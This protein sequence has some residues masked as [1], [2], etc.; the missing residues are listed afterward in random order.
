MAAADDNRILNVL[1]YEEMVKLFISILNTTEEDVKV[2]NKAAKRGQKIVLNCLNGSTWKTLKP[3]L[4]RLVIDLKIFD[5]MNEE[6]DR[7]FSVGYQVIFDKKTGK[8]GV[9]HF[10]IDTTYDKVIPTIPYIDALKG[11]PVGTM[12]FECD[13]DSDRFVLK[14]IVP[15][16]RQVTELLDYDLSPILKM[17]NIEPVS[18]VTLPDGIT[19]ED[20]GLKEL[21]IGGSFWDRDGGT[22]AGYMNGDPLADSSADETQGGTRTFE[23]PWPFPDRQLKR[24]IS[25]PEWLKSFIMVWTIMD[26]NNSSSGQVSLSKALKNSREVF[27]AYGLSWDRDEAVL[28]LN[29]LRRRGLV[30]NPRNGNR[31]DFSSEED[32][33]IVDIDPR[34]NAVW[35]RNVEYIKV[36]LTEGFLHGKE[37]FLKAIGE[38]A[39]VTEIWSK[40]PVEVNHSILRAMM[41]FDESS[42][43]VMADWIFSRPRGSAL[44]DSIALNLDYERALKDWLKLQA[45]ELAG[46]SI[47]HLTAEISPMAGGLGRVE[48]Y[49][50]NAMFE[51]GADSIYVAPWYLNIRDNAGKLQKID[52]AALPN[53]ITDITPY[54]TMETFVQGCKVRFE[55]A[56]GIL[57]IKSGDKV[58]LIPIY[59]IRDI[60]ENYPYRIINLLYEYGTCDCRA[61]I[62]EFTEFFNK[63]ALELIR[64]REVE[65]KHLKESLHEEYKAPVVDANDAQTLPV[66]AFRKAFYS[67]KDRIAPAPDRDEAFFIMNAALFSGTTHTYYN[68]AWADDFEFGKNFLRKA[69]IPDEWLW[70]FLHIFID[71][72]GSWKVV[73]DL[74]SGGVRASDVAKAVAAVHAFEVNRYDPAVELKGLTNGD[75]Y[76]Y[77]SEYFRDALRRTGASGHSQPSSEEI[78]A[79]K[80]YAKQQI[81]LDPRQ[82]VVGYFGR[83]VPEKAGRKSAF[84]DT[85]ITA[86]VKAGIQLIIYGSA[87]WT[88]TMSSELE[89]LE[90][91]LAE[92]KKEEPETYPGRFIFESMFTIDDQRK[93]LAAAD[94]QI[95]ASDRETEAAGATESDIGANAGLQLSTP[96]WEGMIPFMGDPVNRVKMTGNVLIPEKD[97]AEAYLKTVLWAEEQYRKG[98]LVK[99][100]TYAY[101]I[102]GFVDARYTAAAYL[103]F[104]NNGFAGKRAVVNPRVVG[105]IGIDGRY[106]ELTSKTTSGDIAIFKDENKFYIIG[107]KKE[108]GN[109]SK[110]LVLTLSISLDPAFAPFGG[111]RIPE[112]NIFVELVNDYGIRLKMSPVRKIYDNVV[113]YE[114]VIPE[115][116]PLPFQGMIRATSGLWQQTKYFEIIPEEYIPLEGDE[117]I[118][119]VYPLDFS[120]GAAR[121]ILFGKFGML[122]FGFDTSEGMQYANSSGI[123]GFINKAHVLVKEGVSIRTPFYHFIRYISGLCAGCVNED[124]LL[125]HM[126]SIGA[127]QAG[128]AEKIGEL[129][130]FL[131]QFTRHAEYRLIE[132]WIGGL[133]IEQLVTLM[134]GNKCV[135]S[136][137]FNTTSGAVYAETS[138]LKS[139]EAVLRGLSAGRRSDCGIINDFMDFMKYMDAL[140]KEV[141]GREEI[142]AYLQSISNE[143]ISVSLKI[144][145]LLRFVEKLNEKMEKSLVNSFIGNANLD[146][147]ETVLSYGKFDMRPFE[148]Y[149]L[150]GKWMADSAGLQDFLF[151]LK[152]V[153]G[154]GGVSFS[155]YMNYLRKLFEGVPNAGFV[156]DYLEYVGAMEV[157]EYKRFIR[158]L[159]Q[160]EVHLI[161][162]I[163]YYRVFACAPNQYGF[164]CEVDE[165]ASGLPDGGCVKLTGISRNYMRL[166]LRPGT[167]LVDLTVAGGRLSGRQDAGTG[168]ILI[169]AGLELVGALFLLRLSGS[170][171]QVNFPGL[172]RTAG[173]GKFAGDGYTLIRVRQNIL[174][175]A[176]ARQGGVTFPSEEWTGWSR[177]RSVCKLF[178]KALAGHRSGEP[179]KGHSSILQDIFVSDMGGN[180]AGPAHTCSTIS[181][182]QYPRGPA[183]VKTFSFI[184]Y[185]DGGNAANEEKYKIVFGRDYRLIFVISLMSAL[186]LPTFIGILASSG[187]SVTAIVFIL[188]IMIFPVL[189]EVLFRKVLFDDLLLRRWGIGFRAA[190]AISSLIFAVFGGMVI[191]C[192]FIPLFLLGVINVNLFVRSGNLNRSMAVYA[193]AMVLA[194][195]SQGSWYLTSGLFLMAYLTLPGGK[196]TALFDKERQASEYPAYFSG[197]LIFTLYISEVLLS[198]FDSELAYILVHTIVI[199]C[200]TAPIWEEVVWRKMILGDL[201]VKKYG[202]NVSR[203]VIISAVFFAIIHPLTNGMTFLPLNQLLLGVAA[204]YAYIKTG[205][206]R[207]AIIVHAGYNAL[208]NIFGYVFVRMFSSVDM[209]HL[210][211]NL[212]GFPFSFSLDIID[213]SLSL[214][215]LVVLFAAVKFLRPRPED[216]KR[217]YS[218]LMKGEL[219]D[220]GLAGS[221]LTDKSGPG[222]ILSD[223]PT[224]AG[225]DKTTGAGFIFLEEDGGEQNDGAA[226]SVSQDDFVKIVRE[227]M[228]I[229]MSLLFDGDTPI[230]QNM[231]SDLLYGYVSAVWRARGY[232]AQLLKKKGFFL[233]TAGENNKLTFELFLGKAREEL[234]ALEALKNEIKIYGGGNMQIRA[235]GASLTELVNELRRSGILLR[236]N[237]FIALNSGN[238]NHGLNHVLLSHEQE[239]KEWGI[240]SIEEI[241]AVIIE[242]IE[243]GRFTDNETLSAVIKFPRGNGSV[244]VVLSILGDEV[245]TAYPVDKAPSI[246]VDKNTS[247]PKQDTRLLE[248]VSILQPL[249]SLERAEIAALIAGGTIDIKHWEETAHKCSDILQNG[250]LIPVVKKSLPSKSVAVLA[251]ALA[252]L[253]HPQITSAEETS[254]LLRSILDRFA[255]GYAAAN[256]N[257]SEAKETGRKLSRSI[258]YLLYIAG[259]YRLNVPR[260]QLADALIETARTIGCGVNE[261]ARPGDQPGSW[262][263]GEKGIRELGLFFNKEAGMDRINSLLVDVSVE[264]E[265]DGGRNPIDGELREQVISLVGKIPSG[266]LIAEHF[267]K[268]KVL[269]YYADIAG[270]EDDVEGF[271]DDGTVL[272][273]SMAQSI[274]FLALVFVH[275]GEHVFFNAGEYRA[276]TATIRAW[277][278]LKALGI[279]EEGM[280]IFEMDKVRELERMARMDKDDILRKL[281]RRYAP[282]VVG[283]DEVK[284]GGIA[285]YA[286]EVKARGLILGPPA[287][288]ALLYA[289]IASLFLINSASACLCAEHPE[290]LLGVVAVLALVVLAVEHPK[291]FK[292]LMIIAAI[293]LLLYG[294]SAVLPVSAC[295]CSEAQSA[296]PVMPSLPAV[297]TPEPAENVTAVVNVSSQ[298]A[299]QSP[300]A[301]ILYAAAI[302]ATAAYQQMLRTRETIFAKSVNAR[303]GGNLMA[304]DVLIIAPIMLPPIIGARPLLRRALLRGGSSRSL[305]GEMPLVSKVGIGIMIGG[306]TVGIV[307]VMSAIGSDI[308]DLG[309][310]STQFTLIDI[311]MTGIFIALVGLVIV[312]AGSVREDVNTARKGRLGGNKRDGGDARNPVVFRQA[313]GGATLA[314]G[315]AEEMARQDDGR[316]AHR[317]T[318]VAKMVFKIVAGILV[319]IGTF[320]IVLGVLAAIWYIDVQMGLG[321]TLADSTFVIFYLVAMIMYGGADDKYMF[322]ASLLSGVLLA[323]CPVSVLVLS[324][325]APV[326]SMYICGFLFS[327]ASF[328]IIVTFS[329]HLLQGIDEPDTLRVV[330]W[331]IISLAFSPVAALGKAIDSIEDLGEL[332]RKPSKIFEIVISIVGGF[333]I[334]AIFLPLELLVD[335]LFLQCGVIKTKL[336]LIKELF[337]H[338]KAVNF[339]KGIPLYF[340]QYATAIHFFG[341][342]SHQVCLIRR[343]ALDEVVLDDFTDQKEDTDRNNLFNMNESEALNILHEVD[344]TEP[345]CRECPFC[346]LYAKADPLAR[347]KDLKKVQHDGGENRHTT[348]IRAKIKLTVAVLLVPV[349]LVL[350]VIIDVFLSPSCSFMAR[351]PSLLSFLLMA[352]SVVYPLLLCYWWWIILPQRGAQENQEQDALIELLVGDCIILGSFIGRCF[353]EISGN[354]W[355]KEYSNPKDALKLMT[356]NSIPWG[357]IERKKAE[358]IFPALDSNSDLFRVE[359]DT[360]TL[361]FAHSVLYHG[362]DG[363]FVPSI[364]KNGLLHKKYKE[365]KVYFTD[366]PTYATFYGQAIIAVD[367]R[368]LLNN[369]NTYKCGIDKDGLYLRNDLPVEAILWIAVWTMDQKLL[370]NL[371]EYKGPVPLTITEDH[372][373]TSFAAIIKIANKYDVSSIANRIVLDGGRLSTKEVAKKGLILGPPAAK[374]FVRVLITILFLVVPAFACACS[375]SESVPPVVPSL[376]VQTS[377][378]AGVV[379]GIVA[380]VLLV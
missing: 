376:P 333:V 9:D 158:L 145:F 379:V 214:V 197:A 354:G 268:Q 311:S 367:P 39:R 37:E 173:Y 106:L 63:A 292:Y 26:L 140:F 115:D 186:F 289:L 13:P 141:K 361:N 183:I 128:D 196:Y 172:S 250:W 84:T 146:S 322:P 179:E 54:E 315:A 144:H 286:R 44:E 60:P 356:E 181:A 265:R 28:V 177:V 110:N 193:S 40:F 142:M 81:G 319:L 133:T 223:L 213:T 147:A 251:Q 189:D 24:G 151:T 174:S 90:T 61:S 224:V 163:Q 18:T 127:K 17:F 291:A 258:T 310:R 50:G 195:F 101:K 371:R 360:V 324:V 5:L 226:I 345:L 92:R 69:G 239:F 20:L 7:F 191:Q 378:D 358:A 261:L 243:K 375:E 66:A 283:A 235:A 25:D 194:A 337:S 169:D 344:L 149:T 57:N 23:I 134:I 55:A 113:E 77:S 156:M 269:L 221:V 21:R 6:E 351:P 242:V 22:L 343:K 339:W 165:K 298:T 164:K 188:A 335:A 314:K 249:F 332:K 42:R 79:A 323:S 312:I 138:G 3:M 210:S 212:A 100:Q 287:A 241:R 340:S 180:K 78:S 280:N 230:Y 14:Q 153:N 248:L 355:L 290:L 227:L 192:G 167:S 276:W 182:F 112:E 85:N 190:T 293:A 207:R 129:L 123:I 170:R 218:E 171:G 168:I 336:G 260:A 139:F 201:L 357:R 352:W 295:P 303:D 338:R 334:A 83:L 377:P 228:F 255:Q 148:F 368:F 374:A 31:R 124:I 155:D 98:K 176:F 204:A 118:K 317:I 62:W 11:Y 326:L 15:N 95:Q 359:G 238:M 299:K 35:S 318:S 309:S 220:G 94:I 329:F 262:I 64:K 363:K 121:D 36:D 58:N 225:G 157:P 162:H 108:V 296:A 327:L 86:M 285:R 246:S 109:L 143:P 272:I 152:Q 32:R 306:L 45:H 278:E 372:W 135:D 38:Y 136:F 120:I 270:D 325:V 316:L 1:T 132:R 200:I 271:L 160:L 266:R 267:N 65:K 288:K 87:R 199:S 126:R 119:T 294:L 29:G 111:A 103:R 362:L 107:K 67:N 114:L 219:K 99:L 348:G 125:K 366:S 33:I 342:D 97:D 222:S 48:L 341:R 346:K 71:G 254:R 137:I 203:S 263:I 216:A 68:R 305:D 275:V 154:K 27:G 70:L 185:L 75:N 89:T 347:Y 41:L 256:G 53:P 49:H 380:I 234:F 308:L 10:G 247:V 284:D 264:E 364:L 91:E 175:A 331:N 349:F 104:W 88:P 273:N 215:T 237:S 313:D 8:Y 282:E 184:S 73:W 301:G 16:N 321:A 304:Q 206:I 328:A 80:A 373:V 302:F 330:N 102:S 208:C 353:R 209:V 300:A 96:Y 56:R 76:V 122:P 233:R 369:F 72:Y 274:I 74:T 19:K 4:E 59:L 252:G 198:A 46:R 187:A 34:L 231:V 82:M 257:T 116:L 244:E 150:R 236:G 365:N 130:D 47:Y 245:I 320:I 297:F 161:S 307:S 2:I 217:F 370:E 232:D 166:I 277:Q 205:S 159:E 93:A 281:N 178:N 259:G 117:L 43:K 253:K 229:K 279:G 350:P 131:K 240:N 30:V 105:E 211:L 202:I 51:L 52:Y 12:V